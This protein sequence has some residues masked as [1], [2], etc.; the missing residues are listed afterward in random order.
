MLKKALYTGPM[1]EAR[2]HHG[3]PRWLPGVDNCCCS[4]LCGWDCA[5]SKSDI[6]SA[7]CMLQLSWVA[8]IK[9]GIHN[10]FTAST[11]SG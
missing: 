7:N 11:P 2:G 8:N 6:E 1:K 10:V 5:A 3:P 4:S 9:A